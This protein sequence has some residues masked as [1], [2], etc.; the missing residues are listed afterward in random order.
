ML[1]L[2]TDMLELAEPRCVSYHNPGFFLEVLPRRYTL[3]LL[4]SLDF[5]EVDDPSG[6]AQ[7]A[8]RWKFFIH[9]R[10]ESGVSL[11]VGDTAAIEIALPLIRQAHSAARE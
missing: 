9:A 1:A 8:T 6:I 5:N 11:S 10:H 7:D 4:L 2:D 3:T